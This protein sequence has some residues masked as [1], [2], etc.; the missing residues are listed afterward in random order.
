MIL[1]TLTW[2]LT[3]ASLTSASPLMQRQSEN[4]SSVPTSNPPITQDLLNK[5]QLAALS[6]ARFE[7]LTAQGPADTWFKYD[8]NPAANSNPGGG[9]GLGGQGDLANRATF[10]ALINLGVAMSAGFMNPCG[11]NKPHVHPRASEYLTLVKGDSV[12]TGFVLENGLTTQF[13]TTL[14]LYQGAIFLQGS[15]HY[16]SN[17]N[18]EPAVFLTAFSNEDPGLSTIGKNFFALDADVVK[19]DLGFMTQLDGTNMKQLMKR[20]RGHFR[21]GRGSVWR[22]VGSNIRVI[23]LR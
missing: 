5:L 23:A 17:D 4:F 18:C 19:A 10:P 3:T 14:S 7:I 20:F 16:E 9:K 11:M 22:G 12:R 15:I 6:E 1:R 2:A 21:R 8:F 13:S